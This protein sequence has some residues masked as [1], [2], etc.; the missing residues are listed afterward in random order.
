[1][2]RGIKI[3]NEMN[4]WAKKLADENIIERTDLCLIAMVVAK[5]KGF[6]PKSI[7]NEKL[8]KTEI[9]SAG[10]KGQPD[11]SK[12]VDKYLTKNPADI[13]SLIDQGLRHIYDVLKQ[14][15]ADDLLD[16]Y[17]YISELEFE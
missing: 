16:F 1:M 5:K 7:P 8:F 13:G 12:F 14:K 10:Y 15:D 17:N 3:T 11:L 2:I 4:T 9:I 6:K